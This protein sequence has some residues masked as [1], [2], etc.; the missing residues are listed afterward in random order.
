MTRGDRLVRLDLVMYPGF[1]GGPL[2]DVTGRVIGLNTSGLARESRL[3][4]PVTTVSRPR[5]RSIR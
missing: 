5:G 4:L 2:I 3:A 1:S